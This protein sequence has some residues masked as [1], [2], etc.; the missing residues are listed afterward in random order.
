M[1]LLKNKKR[2]RIHQ[3]DYI[4]FFVACSRMLVVTAGVNN[5]M[6]PMC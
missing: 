1:M 3:I 2:K 5:N 4:T 6:N